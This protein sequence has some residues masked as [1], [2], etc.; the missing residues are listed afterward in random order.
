MTRGC[1]CCWQ[2]TEFNYHD[3]QL[4]LCMTE[5]FREFSMN[6]MGIRASGAAAVN[7]CHLAAGEQAALT[8]HGFYK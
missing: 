4:W 7:L 1:C 8:G 6:S 5:L 3:E 2:A